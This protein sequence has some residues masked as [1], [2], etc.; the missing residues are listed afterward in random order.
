MLGLSKLGKGKLLLVKIKLIM[1][2]GHFNLSKSMA[3]SLTVYHSVLTCFVEN[4]GFVN[5]TLFCLGEL[6]FR[7]T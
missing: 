1:S 5:T 2:L 3:G 6:R 4:Q 7:L